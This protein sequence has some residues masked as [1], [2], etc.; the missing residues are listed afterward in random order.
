MTTKAGEL[1]E[2]GIMRTISGSLIDLN[3]FTADMVDIEDIAW[4]LGRTL[5]YG[6]HIVQDWTVA[7]HSI[8]MSYYV[9]KKYALEALLHDAGE[10]YMGDIIWPVKELFP[11]IENFENILANKIM[12][13]YEVKTADWYLDAYVKSTPIKEAD[14]VIFQHE[15]F[16]MGRPGIYHPE[17]EKAWLKA[18]EVHDYYWWAPQYAFLQRFRQLT[19][20]A[21]P[22]ELDIDHL[23]LVWFKEQVVT[24]EEQDKES[25][26]IPGDIEIMAGNHPP[27]YD[28]DMMESIE[29][30]KKENAEI[31]EKEDKKRERDGDS[32][33]VEGELADAV[34]LNDGNPNWGVTDV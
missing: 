27:G 13:K 31:A 32:A 34:E 9:P 3:N 4:G 17:M 30:M 21:D 25:T 15:C 24:A 7:H 26:A 6:G 28:E 23:S 14:I 1:R 5:R 33:V 16:S 29:H 10:A 12:I 8:V 18:I 22:L 11:A 2:A 19:G 20:V